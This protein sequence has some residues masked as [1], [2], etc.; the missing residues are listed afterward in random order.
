MAARTLA[1]SIALVATLLATC[2][3]AVPKTWVGADGGSFG[4]SANWNPAG[5]PG[6][7]DSALFANGTIAST[8]DINFDANATLT[9]LTVATSPLV[10]TGPSRTLSLTSTS[11]SPTSLL[12]GR[13]GS[14]TASATLTSN[15]A[16]LNAVYAMLGADT[17]SS[18]TL[19]LV[20][21][22][23]SVS[24]T[25]TFTDFAIGNWGT[26]TVNVSSGADVSVTG[27]TWLAVY[28]GST[29]NLSITG[30]GSTWTNTGIFRTGKGSGTINV[31]SGATLSAAGGIEL[32]HGR[33]TG[34]GD[35]NASVNSRGGII[36]PSSLTSGYGTLHIT[37]PLTQDTS[38]K[39]EIQL[40]G[41]TAGTFDR[42]NVT[43][44][45]TLAGTLQVT[46]PSFA[47]SLPQNTV[48]D[49]LD[50]T[51]VT[52]TFTSVT[53]PGLSESLEW[54]TS[55][56]YTDG[57]IRV[58]LPGD[59]N[60]NGTVDAA[61]YTL[62]QKGRGTIYTTAD[63]NTWRTHFGKSAAGTG[64]SLDATTSIPEPA[65]LTLALLALCSWPL[66]DRRSTH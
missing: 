45:M 57:T 2:A 27:E 6:P 50:F 24:G 64:S 43:G 26:G 25:G 54:D 30:T 62:W 39:I 59:F 4:T 31:M 8:Y 52:G 66:R 12:I 40:G 32:F 1:C 21:G 9:Q 29:G 49:I 5:A 7:S 46:L 28:G 63:Y 10:F 33:L 61:D 44:A 18:G 47:L 41:T 23:L 37:G 20:A 11:G 56:L 65:A 38:S 34:N 35:I 42:L 14:G 15:L 36:A 53:L 17:G 58:V 51:S 22:A 55:K 48:V 19:N 16:Q 60:N 13:N 3:Q